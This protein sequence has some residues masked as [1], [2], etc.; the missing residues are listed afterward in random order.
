MRKARILLF[1]GIWVAILPYLGF[2]LSWKNVLFTFSGLGLIFLSYVFYR[3]YKK[4]GNKKES[5]DNFSEN[6]I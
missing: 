6:N 2:P 3:E 5:F 1:L 4:V